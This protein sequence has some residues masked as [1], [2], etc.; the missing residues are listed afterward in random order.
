MYRWYPHRKNRD[1]HDYVK[2][3]KETER[4][5]KTLP[6]VLIVL[7]SIWSAVGLLIWLFRRF[8][9]AVGLRDLLSVLPHHAIQTRTCWSQTSSKNEAIK[10]LP[11]EQVV[12]NYSWQQTTQQFDEWPQ[13]QKPK[14]MP[15]ALCSQRILATRGTPNPMVYHH[16]YRSD[17]YN[18]TCEN[19]N[20]THINTIIQVNN[21]Q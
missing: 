9:L 14:A 2:L 17:S 10:D 12:S 1:F 15:S 19:D 3:P 5:L 8:L 18:Q 7:I 20:D 21:S 6:L 4:S 16:S 13:N 11:D